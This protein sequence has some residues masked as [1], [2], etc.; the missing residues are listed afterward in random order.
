M[1]KCF[2]CTK[3][4]DPIFEICYECDNFPKARMDNFIN[5][6]SPVIKNNIPEDLKGYVKKIRKAKQTRVQ[7]LENNN[8]PKSLRRF[9][10]IEVMVYNRILK[11]FDEN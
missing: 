8:Y 10:E 9:L 5:R 4:F 7:R 6:E 3:F 1:W 11:V 2:T